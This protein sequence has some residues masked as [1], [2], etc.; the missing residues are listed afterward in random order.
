[1]INLLTGGAGAAV[2]VLVAMDIFRSLLVPRATTSRMRLGPIMSGGV[3][4]LWQVISDHMS[5][6][7]HGQTVRAGFAPFMLVLLLVMWTALLIFG[8]GAIFWADRGG[9]EPT[10]MTF[11]DAL[12]ASGSAFSTLGVA[13]SITGRFA[14][15]AVVGCSLSGLAIVTVGATFL[16][17]IQGG[18][19]RREALV[20][21]L[22]AHVTLPPSGIAI[23]ETYARE[24]IIPRLGAFF[25]AWEVWAAEVA[26]SHKAFPILLFFRSN[27]SRCEWLAALGAVLDAAALLDTTLVNVPPE[28]RAGAHFV[29]RT[30][31]R[32]VSDLASQFTRPGGPPAELVD[33]D[34]FHSHRTRLLAAGYAVNEDGDTALTL[35][36]ERRASYAHAL[37]AVARRLRID[38]DQHRA[39]DVDGGPLP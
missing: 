6:R 32:L 2:V 23:L 34:R 9:F 18:F 31:A 11:N 16:I 13:G 5:G 1:M 26:I 4:P 20:L 10:L 27:D 36:V 35:Y 21:R 19:G 33:H 22:E 39:G 17:S 25:E 8:F 28:A 12:Y 30:G 14:R 24:G 3:F 37:G 38:V 7:D 15:L 29:L